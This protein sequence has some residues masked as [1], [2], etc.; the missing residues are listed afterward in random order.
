MG[1]VGARIA[2][3]RKLSGLSQAQLAQRCN[4]S[5]SLVRKVEQGVEPASAGFIAA[6]ASALHVEPEQLTGTP[7]YE[8]IEADGPLEGMPELRTLLAEGTYVRPVEPA[9]LVELAHDMA[10]IDLLYRNDKGRVALVRLPTLIRQLYGALHAAS[11]DVERGRAYSLLCA[12]HVTA[13]RLCRRFGFMTQTTP[14]LDRLESL[15]EHADD[16]LY[17]AQA[18]IKR[19]RVLM[20]HDATDTGLE[21][22]ESGIDLIQG[23]TEAANAVRGYGHLCAS[24]VAARGRRADVA[25]VHIDHAR[26]LS[27]KMPSES[28]LYG[29]L[30]GPANVEIHSCAVEMESGD[31]A[32]AARDGSALMLPDTIAPPRA[33]HHWQDTARAWLMTGQPDQALK[34]L[35]VARRIAPQQT[36]LHPGV[37]ETL[38]GVAESE[39]RRTE[40]LSSFARWVGVSL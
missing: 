28:D 13:E 9:P 27:T 3:E 29:T 22:A 23:D 5:I 38:L 12:A 11:S 4:Y 16:P 21:L 39:R 37:R 31:P 33:G 24:I 18:R 19:A 32:K 6:A 10:E 1:H 26:G 36:R 17:R 25:R 15:A 40:S 20:Y 30:F 2:T 35:N 7:Y 14:A 8:T 34:A